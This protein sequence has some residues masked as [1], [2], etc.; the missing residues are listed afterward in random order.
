MLTKSSFVS[1]KIKNHRSRPHVIKLL[2]KNLQSFWPMLARCPGFV[3]VHV[4]FGRFY[5]TD[6]SSADVD[7]GTGPHRKM[8]DLL[9]E[10]EGV[11]RERIGFSTILSRLRSDADLFVKYP[12]SPWVL[13]GEDLIYQIQCTLDD[14]Q[15]TIDVDATTFD[16]SCHGPTSELGCTLVH[17][18]QRAWDLKLAVNH[19]SNLNKSPDQ[20][21]IGQAITNSLQVRFV[22]W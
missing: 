20:K 9:R 3:T 6:L 5:L 2:E 16:F 19:S 1:K 7:I 22:P 18:V 10:L 12:T 15:L 21:N 13:L 17:C 4:Q 14:K 11:E 8:T